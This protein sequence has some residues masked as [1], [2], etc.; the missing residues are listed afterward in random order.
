MCRG[1]E[2]LDRNDDCD[3]IVTKMHLA[4]CQR[5]ELSFQ[6][7]SLIPVFGLLGK[8]MKSEIRLVRNLLL[9]HV[10]ER[11]LSDVSK[12]ITSSA[13]MLPIAKKLC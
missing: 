10:H 2:P 4:R 5:L 3:V 11:L 12:W 9:S 8:M 1:L 7:K 6:R 13:G